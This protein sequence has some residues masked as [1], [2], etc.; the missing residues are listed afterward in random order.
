MPPVQLR[1]P[2]APGEPKQPSEQ[3]PTLSALTWSACTP[4]C[5]GVLPT[6]GGDA[7]VYGEALSAPGGID[8]VRPLMGVYT[9]FDML[10]NE[11]TGYEHLMLYGQLKVGGGG[12]G[13]MFDV[14]WNELTGCSAACSR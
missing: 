8:R 10:W 5:A 14:L 13:V 7:L 9:Q 4:I 6:S 11:L 2:A 12:K 1:Q 3:D